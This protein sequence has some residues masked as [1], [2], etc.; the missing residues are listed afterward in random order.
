[1]NQNNLSF[2]IQVKKETSILYSIG[3]SKK[4]TLLNNIK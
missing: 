1:M 3:R 2:P 4:N